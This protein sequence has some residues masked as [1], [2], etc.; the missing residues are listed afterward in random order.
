MKYENIK[1]LFKK[2]SFHDC[3]NEFDFNHIKSRK[4]SLE[5]EYQENKMVDI[6]ISKKL[7]DI[8]RTQKGIFRNNCI[9]SLDRINVVLNMQHSRERRT[10]SG[11]SPIFSINSSFIPPSTNVFVFFI[12]NYFIFFLIIIHYF[13]FL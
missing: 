3:L 10:F 7:V 12:F 4:E 1:K 9:D 6:L 5:D 11:I 8:I 13:H 2:Q